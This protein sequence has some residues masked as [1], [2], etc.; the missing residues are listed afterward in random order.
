MSRQ[1]ND[2]LYASPTSYQVTVLHICRICNYIQLLKNL[3][4]YFL[5][6]FIFKRFR[7]ST[8]FQALMSGILTVTRKLSLSKDTTLSLS[9]ELT[10][11]VIARSASFFLKSVLKSSMSLSILAKVEVNLFWYSSDRLLSSS[12]VY[13]ALLQKDTY[14]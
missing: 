3:Q 12:L 1:F 4:Y 13:V 10:F 6:I 2:Y 14:F 5:Q 8:Y 7:E 9:F 11:L